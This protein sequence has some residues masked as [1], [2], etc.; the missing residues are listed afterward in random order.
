V[1]VKDRMVRWA[2][3]K[4]VRA[5]VWVAGIGLLVGA[6]VGLAAG[7][8]IE[9]HRV[10]RDLARLNAQLAGATT[11]TRPHAR[12][13]VGT[14]SSTFPVERVGN[15]AATAPG[16]ITLSTKRHGSVLLHLTASTHVDQAVNGAP[17]D[18]AV[19]RHVLVAKGAHDL[20]VLPT[21]SKVGRKVTKVAN[22]VASVTKIKGVAQLQLSKVQTV[23]TTS[24]ATPSDIK[25]GS[26]VLAWYLPG[27]K[28]TP[29]A[30]EIIILPAGSAFA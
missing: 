26:H 13:K 4:P 22:G 29:D 5:I 20:I 18:I 14:G 23:D 2:Q 25:T 15:V 30:V 17:R 10:H 7:F 21:G 28:G 12:S 27:A 24:T 8:K 3:S 6:V 1:A 19:D 11:A 16:T 9:Q